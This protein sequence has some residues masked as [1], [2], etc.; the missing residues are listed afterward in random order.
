MTQE[1]EMVTK[2]CRKNK[3]GK[4]RFLMY[5]RAESTKPQ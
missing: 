4:K 3:Q 1:N 5:R 2:Y